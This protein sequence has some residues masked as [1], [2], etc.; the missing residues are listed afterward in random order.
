MLM[1]YKY[2]EE[3]KVYK[4]EKQ[5]CNFAKYE[6]NQ[7]VALAIV[8]Y[9]AAT[10]FVFI[11]VAMIRSLGNQGFSYD[12]R[13][14]R[15]RRLSELN[16]LL[17]SEISHDILMSWTTSSQ[18]SSRPSVRTSTTAVSC[19]PSVRTSTAAV[20]CYQSKHCR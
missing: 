7:S 12:Q 16:R 9:G 11:F 13:I 20:S 14:L 17:Y 5:H 6:N 18:F 15:I 3:Q 8:W 19:S 10:S 2:K 1:L 4:S